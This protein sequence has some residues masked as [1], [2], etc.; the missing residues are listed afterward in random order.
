MCRPEY[1]SLH[2]NDLTVIYLYHYEWPFLH[3]SLSDLQ[4]F[5]YHNLC[6]NKK[7]V[8]HRIPC[9]RVF[10][11]FAKYVHSPNLQWGDQIDCCCPMLSW[12]QIGWIVGPV[13]KYDLHIID[14]TDLHIIEIIS[15][16]LWN[17]SM[18]QDWCMSYQKLVTFSP[19]VF[20]PEIKMCFCTCWPCD[21]LNMQTRKLLL[22]GSPI[23]GLLKFC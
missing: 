4:Y 15:R 17:K 6:Q 7:A 19:L 2:S 8:A 3:I 20:S 16:P 9:Q 18:V 13:V 1:I 10:K 14:P 12:C 5:F 21:L 11:Y 23:S 22:T